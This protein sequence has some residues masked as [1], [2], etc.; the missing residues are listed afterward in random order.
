MVINIQSDFVDCAGF[1]VLTQGILL[2]QYLGARHGGCLK[3]V[4]RVPVVWAGG[5][6]G[7]TLDC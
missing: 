4:L 2:L 3:S 5:S 6:V 7:S 1:S